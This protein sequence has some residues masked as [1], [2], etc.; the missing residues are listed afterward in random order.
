MFWVHQ[1]SE[2]ISCTLRPHSRRRHGTVIPRHPV[3]P[4]PQGALPSMFQPQ[5]QVLLPRAGATNCHY[6]K[7]YYVPQGRSATQV[8][9]STSD[10]SASAAD[11]P[12][13]LI[14]SSVVSLFRH[15]VYVTFWGVYY[16]LQIM[17]NQ[18]NNSAHSSLENHENIR[19]TRSRVVHLL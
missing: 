14:F 2:G 18:R 16:L 8:L 1:P 6:S 17:T 9:I 10:G 4:P 15:H 7:N 12:S 3:I 13:R 5:L 19:V 11:A